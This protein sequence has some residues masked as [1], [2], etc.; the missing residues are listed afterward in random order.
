MTNPEVLIRTP[1]LNH[2]QTQ[3]EPKIEKRLSSYVMAAGA[4][5]VGVLTFTLPADAEVVYT[6]AHVSIPELGPG[7][8][9]DLNGDGI[10][11]FGVINQTALGHI[12]HQSFAPAVLGNAELGYAGSHWMFASALP[13]GVKV[14]PGG[15]FGHERAVMATWSEESGVLSSRGPW[16][17]AHDKYVGVAFLIDGETHYGWARIRIKV[18]KMLLTGYAYETIPNQ[19]INTGQTAE[20]G[21]AGNFKPQLSPAENDTA[22]TSPMLGWLAQGASGIVAWRRESE[23]FSA[24]A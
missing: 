9:L 23:N 1:N 12:G 8:K 19:P 7:F 2:A 20:A 15:N 14:G 24:A 21:R 13:A 16:K 5:G 17:N 22:P 6:P 4:A 18:S 11:D 10:V 3:L